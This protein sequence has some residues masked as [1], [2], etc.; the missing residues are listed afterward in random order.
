MPKLRKEKFDLVIDTEQ[1]SRVTPLIAYY[2]KALNRIGFNPARE[3]RGSLFTM[4]VDYSDETYEVDSFLK[5][6]EPLRIKTEN[7]KLELNIKKDTSMD[8]LLKTHN[9]GKEDT[10]IAIH[11][12]SS[13]DR[14]HKRCPKENFA[15]VIRL[16]SKEKIKIVILGSKEEIPLAEE[17]KKLSKVDPIILCGKTSI[18]QLPYFIKNMDIL[19]GNDSSLMHIATA[20]GTPVVAILSPKKFKK[21]GPRGEHDIIVRKDLLEKQNSSDEFVHKK[22]ITVSDVMNSVRNILK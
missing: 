5:L 12:G 9:L 22:I 14:I 19:A 21:W 3:K 17:I 16:L 15:E 13:N 8:L 20:V 2:S 10:L 18:G 11:P 1:F 7:R 6:L 4:K